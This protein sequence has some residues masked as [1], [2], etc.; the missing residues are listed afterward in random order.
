MYTSLTFSKTS[1]PNRMY[2][3]VKFSKKH[4]VP[5]NVY[6]TDI[7]EKHIVPKRMYMAL[8]FY[9]KSAVSNIVYTVLQSASHKGQATK[10]PNENIRYFPLLAS[11]AFRCTR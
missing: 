5:S 11:T 9:S 10:K 3:V 7:F 6:G 1:V 4:S 2:T 8:I